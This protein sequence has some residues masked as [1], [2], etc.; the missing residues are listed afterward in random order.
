MRSELNLFFFFS[1]IRSSSINGRCEQPQAYNNILHV[2]ICM[3]MY[4]CEVQKCVYVGC[5]CVQQAR[6]QWSGVFLIWLPP[7]FLRQSLSLNLEL[8]DLVRLSASQALGPS[9]LTPLPQAWFFYVGIEMNSGSQVGMASALLV[10][11][12]LLPLLLLKKKKGRVFRNI[13]K[14]S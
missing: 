7:Q 11:S 9:H 10:E 6:G 3:C 14:G 12:F 1:N 5:V 8:T 2:Y 4:T 13:F